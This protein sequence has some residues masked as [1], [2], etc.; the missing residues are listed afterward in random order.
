MSAPRIAARAPNTP[1]P[2]AR[3]WASP[4]GWAYFAF[5]AV[6]GWLAARDQALD[7]AAWIGIGLLLA[8]PIL[9]SI[10]RPWRGTA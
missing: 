3:F 7:P 6:G 2:A 4:I 10:L 9:A 8:S 5:A 1:S